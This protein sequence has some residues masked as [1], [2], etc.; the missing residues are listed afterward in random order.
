M[1]R[2][3][4]TKSAKGKAFE[5]SV[6]G[7]DANEWA[8]AEARLREYERVV[9]GL[10]EMIAVVDRDYRY[11]IANKA[12]LNQRGMRAE[13]VI[14]R[15]VSE[16]LDPTIF[17]NAIKPRLDKA[18][19]GNVVRYELKYNY[20]ELGQRDVAI[21][22][23]PIEG[24]GG[25]DRVAC[26][27]RD[28]T[29][30]KLA[31]EALKNSETQMAEAQ[32]LAH[33]G[34]W[35]WDVKT[36][37]RS[38]SEE[39]FRIF[40]F[41]P[42]GQVPSIESAAEIVHPEDR[43]LFIS[44]VQASLASGE[45]FNVSYRIVRPD[46]AERIIHSRGN[47][48]LDEGGNAISMFGTAQDIT[49]RWRREDAL[50]EAERK[51]REIFECAGEGIFQSTPEGR[52][53]AANPALAEM[54]GYETPQELIRECNDISRQIYA[55]S[56]RRDEF[57]GLIGTQGMVRGFEIQ[58]FRK[59]GT[60]F[61]IMVN[62][63]AVRDRDGEIFYYEGTAQDISDWK[64]AESR[65][66]AFA[67][68]AHKL[69]GART[70]HD[71]ARIITQTA[72][73]LFG[74]DAC[75]LDLY[76]A[77]T[78]QVYPLLNVDTINGRQV[79]VTPS[80]SVRPPTTRSRRILEHGPELI[81][82]Q[83]PIKFDSDSRPF[84]DET[85]PT[86]SIMC[87]PIKHGEDIVGL[88]SIQ[89][90]RINAYDQAALEDLV[91]LAEHCGE[92]INRIRAEELLI[93]SEER[94][95]D[96][97][98][99]SHELIC[100]HD[101]NGLVLSANRAAELALGYE[102]EA[103]VGKGNIRDILAPEVRDQFA[104]Y[105]EMLQKNGATSGRMVVQTRSG[106]KR[107]WEYYNS[108]RTEGV[109][110]P[111]VR[112]MARDITEQQRAAKALS[113]SEARYRELFENSHDAIYV[114]DL[115]GRYLSVNRAAEELSGFKREEI[116]G[117]HYSNFIAPR[118]LK[119]ARESFCRKLDTPIETTY[120][121][122]VVCKNGM[123]KPVEVNS[124][125]IYKDGVAIGV[126]GTARDIS[127]RRRAQEVLRS[128]SRSLIAAQEAE[129]QKI[130]RE[131]HDEIGQVLTAVRL[132]LQSIQKTCQTEGCLPRIG[133]SVEVVD[134]A[135]AQVRELS[136]ELRPS[137]LDDLGLA[138]ALR[139]YADRYAL[140]SGIAAEVSGDFQIGRIPHDVETA[141]FR[142]A[143][144]ALTN[145]ARHSAA[146]KVSLCFDRQ[147][148]QLCM[149]IRDNGSGFDAE[150]YLKGVSSGSALGLRG[151]QERALAVKGHVE[152][153]SSPAKGTQ[154]VVKV[155]L[156]K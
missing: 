51:Y 27:L 85:R 119:D 59:D 156:S 7:V 76:D 15:Q 69:S 62:A 142:I 56:S 114:H 149:T 3:Q 128:Y 94:Y 154:V 137:L 44:V 148:G 43:E 12:F 123:R 126:Q 86:A 121:A 77:G 36:N 91:A 141:C 108:L 58:V 116:L 6:P 139:W 28:I 110:T 31:E 53:I 4:K 74:W 61:W 9:E 152:I 8:E 132:N 104:E 64:R 52:Y 135:L 102:L 82:R 103:F 42:D 20:R 125:M 18:F 40:G 70:H 66:G 96:L 89:S 32:H 72:E 11:L 79:E 30:R 87:V 133:E 48:I 122:E 17:E 138:A 124:R 129:R 118:H 117:K 13:E 1:K 155:P 146:T 101:L 153:N 106:E 71:A 38:W 37:H 75:N 88:F 73:E 25:V 95:R 98:E 54:Y 150:R 93:E 39:L 33:I 100:T 55:D 145:T 107:I 131:L 81:L 136:L 21:S 127:E 68:L 147:N 49:G 47:V 24:P 143:Q 111:I 60:K 22:Y 34:S 46:G 140:R 99:H 10:Q 65:S 90:Y 57:M 112:G 41:P 115:N 23:F 120:E 45:P 151:M 35:H 83:E 63:R 130:A 84:G 97:V 144:E 80:I 67:A 26:V 14:G 109:A 78:D 105:M 5:T 113:E 16:V 29:E 19:A 2:V 134:Q 92:A 50:R